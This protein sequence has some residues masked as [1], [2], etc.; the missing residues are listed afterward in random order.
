MSKGILTCGV[1][2]SYNLVFAWK[3]RP[4]SMV[5]VPDEIRTGHHL[6]G[7]QKRYILN[8]VPFHS[9]NYIT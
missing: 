3:G 6:Y 7:S 2:S 5:C 9:R 4:E 8:Q 1:I